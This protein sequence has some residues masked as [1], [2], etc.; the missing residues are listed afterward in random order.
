ML[1]HS[2][3]LATLKSSIPFV[4]YVRE[5]LKKRAADDGTSISLDTNLVKEILTNSPEEMR[6][7]LPKDSQSQEALYKAVA[8]QIIIAEKMK[9]KDS[10]SQDDL[11]QFLKEPFV[12]EVIKEIGVD[13]VK[14]SN[15]IKSFF[16]KLP[17]F[18][19]CGLNF[20]MGLLAGLLGKKDEFNLATSI[21]QVLGITENEL[22]LLA[23][24]TIPL[25][26]LPKLSKINE[27]ET[28]V[29]LLKGKQIDLSLLELLPLLLNSKSA[30][31]RA[32]SEPVGPQPSNQGLEALQNVLGKVLDK[33]GEVDPKKAQKVAEAVAEALG[34]EV[35]AKG[36]SDSSTLG[37][38]DGSNNNSGKSTG[39]IKWAIG[40]ALGFLA[41]VGCLVWWKTS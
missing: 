13:E 18:S 22:K 23:A 33:A 29:N 20:N 36:G 3:I 10:I 31:E 8:V 1:D 21:I 27:N 5:K 40:G 34:M 2:K 37:N 12:Q 9:E 41:M 30:A 17:K 19:A 14:I 15:Y 6:S 11:Q 39:W 24:E 7:E 35:P 28:L 16:A 32:S 4:L 26:L 38:K 25:S